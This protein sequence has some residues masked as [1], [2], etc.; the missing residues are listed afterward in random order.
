[1]RSLLSLLP[2]LLV[3]V[4]TITPST[5]NAANTAVIGGNIYTGQQADGQ[6]DYLTAPPLSGAKVMV[7]NQHSGGAFITYGTV[8]GNNWSAEVP[9]PGDY[10]VMFSAPG[11]DTTSREFT[12]ENS[13]NVSKD[14]YLPPLPLPKANLLF[15]AFHDDYTNGEDDAP[16]D[17]P[18]NGITVTVKDEEGNIL[19]IKVTGAETF[20]TKDGLLFDKNAGGKSQDGF[21]YFTNLPP[22]EVIVSSDPS[23]AYMHS[24]P[25]FNFTESSEYYLTT[26]EEGGRNWDPKLYPGDPGTEAGT[27]LIWHGYIEKLGQIGDPTNS[28]PFNPTITGSI[29]GVL[30]DADGN[31][32]AEPFPP[33]LEYVS[34]NGIVPDGALFLVANG[35]S[36]KVRPIA[37]TE[38]DSE[39]GAFEFVNVPPGNYKIFATD[40]PI[41]YVWGQQAVKVAPQTHW[42]V[43]IMLPRFFARAQG[44][45][46]N[47]ST[48]L[49]IAGAQVNMR[50][51]DGSIWKT[52]IADNDG[53]YNFDDLP[54]VEVM[55]YVDVEPPLSTPTD[56]F[57]NTIFRG[58]KITESFDLDGAGPQPAVDVTYNSNTAYIQWFTF[59]YRADLQLE[60]IPADTGDVRGF[61]YYDHLATGT[62]EGNESYDREEERT[63]HGAMVE[64]YSKDL[65]TSEW[66]VLEASTTTGEFSKA[67]TLAQGWKEPYTWPPDEFGGVFRGPLPGYYE[68]RGL[69][70]GEY[71]V[72]VIPP[73]GYSYS[74]PTSV[75]QLVNV[76]GGRS[77]E[78]NLGLNTTPAGSAIGVPLAG[79]IEGGVFDDLNVDYNGQSLLFMEKAG[80]PGVPVGVYDHL[81]Y[82]LGSGHMGNPLCYAGS[83]VCPVGEPPVQ[84]PEMERRFAPGVHIYFGNDPSLP[85]YNS[86]YL[87]LALSY[88]FGQGQYKFEA[89]WS[90]VPVAFGG[91]GGAMLPGGPVLPDNAPVIDF[92]GPG[93]SYIVMGRNF[94]D[95]QGYSTVS[96]SGRKLKV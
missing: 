68:F 8:N 48:G 6:P 69:A 61:I 77:G 75:N 52:E 18:L 66:S 63:I 33:G 58:V 34:P 11:H 28:T 50:L 74:P 81:G 16:D 1:M 53:W 27:Y 7:Q 67:L 56:T 57:D 38:A 21:V 84:K 36:G 92:A 79:E 22:G 2:A 91:F 35:E 20:T 31:D 5:V 23:T 60:E 30:L 65:A 12:V 72:K 41:D 42:P 62:W 24:N 14:A 19:D 55:G 96:L 88:Q 46:T 4:I 49:A 26:S 86:N 10:V 78:V 29:S 71:M 17:P 95:K 89:D 59:N 9:A 51:K 73:E 25:D 13:D 43:L 15:Y 94:G 40:V 83:T 3:L 54:E 76:Y 87:P 80:I 32:P 39:T 47:S 93:G 44:Y 90:L 85:G 70:P 82:L 45:I 64:L 37:T